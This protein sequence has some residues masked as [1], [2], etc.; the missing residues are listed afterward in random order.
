MF[1]TFYYFNRK[2]NNEFI[3]TEADKTLIFLQNTSIRSQA[4]SVNTNCANL[5]KMLILV[6]D[7]ERKLYF[8]SDCKWFGN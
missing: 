1:S 5:A 8:A 3:F 7:K 6:H 4:E 2:P